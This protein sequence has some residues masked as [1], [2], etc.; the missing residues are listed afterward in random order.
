[1]Y[2]KDELKLLKTEFWNSFAAYCEVQPYLR[3]RR[4]MWVLYN[5]KVRG[6]E[7][8][9]DLDRRG[10]SVVL[11]VNHR[12]EDERLEMFERLSWYKEMLGQGFLD[13][14]VWDVCFVRETGKQVAR[15]YVRCENL[16]FHRREDWGALFSFMA[17]NMYLLEKNFM[18]IA[19]YLRE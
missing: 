5:T 17:R 7:L 18:A 4:K 16:D 11:E 9:F 6:V 8:K 19:E 13:G 10:A 2:K 14:L 1:M 3:G 12:Q 15:V